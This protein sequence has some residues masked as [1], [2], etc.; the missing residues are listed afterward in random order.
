MLGPVKTDMFKSN[1]P[2]SFIWEPEKAAAY[3]LKSIFK[4]KKVIVF[5]IF[6]RLFFHILQILPTKMTARILR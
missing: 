1:K 5:P 4:G 6:W 3:I 2:L